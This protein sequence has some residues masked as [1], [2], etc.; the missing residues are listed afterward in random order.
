VE[1]IEKYCRKAY[2]VEILADAVKGEAEK[3]WEK[4]GFEKI[5]RKDIKYL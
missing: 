4:M 3:F 1:T 2:I 5:G